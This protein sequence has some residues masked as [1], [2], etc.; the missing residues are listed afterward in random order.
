MEGTYIMLFIAQDQVPRYR[1][2]D[3]TYG[4]IVVDYIPQK[5][6]PHRSRLTVGGNLI[7]YAGY[8]STPTADITKSNMIIKINIYAPGV[9][10]MCCDIKIL[11]GNKIEYI[12]ANK[13]Y[14]RYPTRGDHYGI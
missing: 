14:Y 1:L 2:K 9:R 6:E 11:L 4:H 7:V 10:Y 8:A 12:R 3:V 5:K 13:N